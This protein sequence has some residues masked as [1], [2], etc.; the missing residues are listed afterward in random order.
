MILEGKFAE[1]KEELITPA[2]EVTGVD[3]ED[4]GDV[5]PDVADGDSL[6]VKL[7][8]SHGFV[9]KHGGA[10]I[11]WRAIGRCRGTPG[12]PPDDKGATAAAAAARARAAR[13]RASEARLAALSRSWAVASAYCS[14]SSA[15]ASAASQAAARSRSSCWAAAAAALAY[16]LAVRWAT[17][18]S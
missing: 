9:L 16:S 10:E 15:R 13:V 14:A 1:D 4:G 5:V 7:K 3:V 17:S 12:G 18:S 8:Q 2:I 11:R 6:G